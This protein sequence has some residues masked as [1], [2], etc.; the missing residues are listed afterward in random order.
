MS[1]N[2]MMKVVP[3]LV[4]AAVLMLSGSYIAGILTAN[5]A[6]VNVTGTAYEDSYNTTTDAQAATLTLFGPTGL[7]IFLGIVVLTLAWVMKAV[8]Y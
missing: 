4:V 5:N 8:R 7:I 2:P 3:L 1:R 6:D